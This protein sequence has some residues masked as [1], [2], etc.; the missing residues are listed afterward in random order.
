MRNLQSSIAAKI[1]AFLLFLLFLA[2]ALG[3]I[4]SILYVADEGYY[5]GTYSF[6]SS[7]KCSSITYSYSAAVFYDY[8]S[9]SLKQNPSA[10]DSF[11][12]KQYQTEFAKE[13]TNFFFTVTDE[14]GKVILTN[15]AEQD[16]GTQKTYNIDPDGT[17]YGKAYIV[18]AYVKDPITAKDDYYAPYQLSLTLY[19]MRYSTI[20]ITVLSA[21]LSVL[22]FAFLMYS[23]GHRKGREGIVLNAADRIP[24]DLYAFGISVAGICSFF[25]CSNIWN[26]ADGIVVAIITC[27]LAVILSFLSITLCMTF[28]AR[29]KAGKWWHN[30]VI[31][32]VLK[33][34]ICLL[35]NLPLLLKTILIFASYILIN[36]FLVILLMHSGAEILLL[37]FLFN[38]AV[39]SGLCFIVLQLNR[40]KLGGEK[41]AAGDYS[42]K[43]DAEK[44]FW[45]IKKHAETLNNIRLGMSKA[46]EER[47]KSER[48][49]T[50]LITNVSHDIKTPLTSIVSYVDLLKRESIKNENALKYID[51]LDRQSAKLKKL[52]EDLVEASK[53]STGNISVKCGR[54]DVVEFLNQSVGEY[55]EHFAAGQLEVVVHTPQDETAIMADGRLMWRVFDN[56]LDNICKYSLPNTRVYF[57]IENIGGAVIIT[58]KNISR[59]PLNITADELLERF[60]RGDNARTT[61][62]SGLGLSI[63]KSLT[64]LQMGSFDLFVDGDLFKVHVKFKRLENHKVSTLS[65]T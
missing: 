50:E 33:G 60:M 4:V 53:A 63:A 2:A 17:Q 30:T 45:D 16:F 42:C 37:G 5:S 52:T 1:A 36:G 21:I 43:I 14:S 38:M 26:R 58:L 55:A 32:I 29:V 54:M 65:R 48:L 40:L 34:I 12:L 51:V 62:G 18:N 41:I 46:V 11:N 28:S 19:S 61:E 22:L 10:E 49:K 25:I 35:L 7:R 6:F 64:E 24:F 20:A 31:Y 39:L 57:D 8:L 56:L 23:A 27:T 47:L 13:N 15:Y 44:L 3:G 9:L 59:V